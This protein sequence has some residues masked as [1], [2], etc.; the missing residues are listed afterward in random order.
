MVTKTT[1][2]KA[3][4]GKAEAPAALTPERERALLELLRLLHRAELLAEGLGVLISDDLFQA[5]LDVGARLA[6]HDGRLDGFFK[7]GQSG[8]D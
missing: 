4:N 3:A 2:T 8:A 6:D 7:L 5:R 1:K